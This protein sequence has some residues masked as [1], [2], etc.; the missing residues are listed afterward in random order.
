MNAK[1][2]WIAAAALLSLSLAAGATEPATQ[3]TWAELSPAQRQ[4]LAPLQRDWSSIDAQRRAKWIEL[5]AR[6]PQLPAEE[7]AR[8]HDRMADWARLSPGERSRARLQ[9]QQ[10]RQLPATE[11][12][13]QWEAYQALSDDQRQ[14]LAQRAKPGSKPGAAVVA[15]LQVTPGADLAKRNVVQPTAAVR[16]KAVT[17][18]TQQVRPGA[19]TTAMNSPALPPAHHQA[20]LPK[21]AATRG[22]VDPVT[23]LPRRGPQGAAVYSAVSAGD[24][25]AQE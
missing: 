25:G 19:T 23:L 18:I 22:F 24:S 8:M 16:A 11:R 14:A 6:Y 20:G 1:A 12:E 17:P 5:A 3:T 7:R 21:I 15:P 9:F 4:A 13:A 10:S 2:R